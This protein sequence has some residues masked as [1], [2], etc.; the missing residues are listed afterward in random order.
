ML[1]R[2]SLRLAWLGSQPRFVLESIAA[3]GVKL[4]GSHLSGW[5]SQSLSTLGFPKFPEYDL[6]IWVQCKD[7]CS[8]RS[9]YF[10][11]IRW[12]GF[13]R[14]L[15]MAFAGSCKRA[16]SLCWF[17]NYHLGNQVLISPTNLLVVTVP[18]W[19]L[20][21]RLSRLH[22]IGEP[23]A[24]W[25]SKCPAHDVIVVQV[26][27]SL[28]LLRWWLIIGRG[29]IKKMHQNK[30]NPEAGKEGRKEGRKHGRKEGLKEGM[31][32]AEARKEGRKE[33]RKGGSKEG[34][35]EWRK[36]KLGRK[37]GSREGR[38][39]SLVTLP[40]GYFCPLAW[41]EDKHVWWCPAIPWPESSP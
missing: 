36:Q 40:R 35:K 7:G 37:E 12:K 28:R 16:E 13:G 33:G 4:R 2:R 10:G 32:E 9:F 23:P 6:T 15:T 39:E 38:K 21:P 22:G 8:C 14:F 26:L 34:R 31:K 19:K 27:S 3:E 1:F 25:G 30:I 5:N 11:C 41:E 18:P 17:W 20:P 29:I 24:A